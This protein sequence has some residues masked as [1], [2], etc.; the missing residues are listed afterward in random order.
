MASEYLKWKFRDIQ[1]EQPTELTPEQK[2]RNWWHYHKW[3]VAFAAVAVLVLADIGKDVLGIGR[4]RPDYQVAY[5]G[6]AP[7]PDDTADA[8][9][10]ALTALGQDANGDGRVVVQINDYASGGGVDGGE[11]AAASAVTLMGDIADCESCFFL[12]EDPEAFQRSYHILRRLDGSLPAETD[13]DY[14]SCCLR[15][16]DCPVLA[17]QALGEYHSSVA[18]QERS[19]SNQELLGGLYLARRGFWTE[20]TAQNPEACDALWAAMTEGADL[21]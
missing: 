19:G 11:Y 4:I 10:A 14:E 8:L 15:W 12:L 2:R 18:G 6:T 16:A 7:L 17:R 13:R 20:R 1:P 5:V 9:Q 21:K 3:H